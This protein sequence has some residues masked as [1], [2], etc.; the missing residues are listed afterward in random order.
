MGS[1]ASLTNVDREQFGDRVE[2]TKSLPVESFGQDNTTSAQI[3]GE[4]TLSS[5]S[6]SE[7][8]IRE[9]STSKTSKSRR[10]LGSFLGFNNKFKCDEIERANSDGNSCNSLELAE[11]KITRLQQEKER[12]KRELES[13]R[14]SNT[15]WQN[16]TRKARDDEGQAKERA[17]TFEDGRLIL[18][19]Q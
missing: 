12:L 8:G 19:Y 5:A 6:I 13:L 16:E 11:Y 14:K 9:R 4:K 17:K 18:V 3:I 15:K 7:G 2:V 10:S 1:A